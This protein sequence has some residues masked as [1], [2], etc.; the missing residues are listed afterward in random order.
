MLGANP[1][2]FMYLAGPMFADILHLPPQPRATTA[3]DADGDRAQLGRVVR[4]QAGGVEFDT[5]VRIDPPPR[6]T[7]PATAASCNTFCD[8]YSTARPP[9][10]EHDRLTWCQLDRIAK[11][12]SGHGN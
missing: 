12:G 6:P 8:N 11:R 7:T 10:A 1:S 9:I 3:L 4:V 2:V 5:A